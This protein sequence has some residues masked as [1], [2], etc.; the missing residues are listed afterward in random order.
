VDS[1]TLIRFLH[2]IAI[3]FF[4]GGQLMLVVAVVPAVRR[5]DV[6]DEV[7]RGVAMRFGIGSLV[8]LG[9]LLVTG[10]AMASHFGRWDD[11]VLHAKLILLALIGVLTALH[12]VTPYA[13]AI[14]IAVFLTSLAIVWLGVV[15]AH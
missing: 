8:A 10:A 6:R 3:A 7:I 9:V 12:V 15:L 2:V 13:R 1:W 14:S 5:L 4:V 11:G